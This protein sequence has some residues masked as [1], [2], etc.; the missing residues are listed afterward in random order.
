MLARVRE[1]VLGVLAGRKVDVYLFG[2][3]ARGGEMHY[4]DIDV[5]I[6]AQEPLSASLRVGLSEALENSTIPRRV[7]I[8]DLSSCGREMREAVRREGVRWNA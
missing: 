6:D 5:A 1:I 3:F 7:E 8:V 4:S 2:S